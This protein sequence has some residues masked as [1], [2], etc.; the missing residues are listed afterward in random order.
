MRDETRP[1][2]SPQRVMRTMRY[3]T[4]GTPKSSFSNSIQRSV[5]SSSPTCTGAPVRVIRTL[6]RPCAGEN[7]ERQGDDEEA[8]YIPDQALCIGGEGECQCANNVPAA[9]LA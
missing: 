6:I 9:A 5:S 3:S 2:I 7:D 1:L 4:Y 8:G